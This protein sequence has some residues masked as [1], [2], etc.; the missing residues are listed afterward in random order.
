MLRLMDRLSALVNQLVGGFAN[1]GAGPLLPHNP[2]KLSIPLAPAN[3]SMSLSAQA[4][5]SQMTLQS[6]VDE[7]QQVQPLH[8]TVNAT[9]LAAPAAYPITQSPTSQSLI[10]PTASGC[11]VKILHNTRDQFPSSPSLAGPQPISFFEGAQNFQMRDVINVFNEVGAQQNTL[12]IQRGR[13]SALLKHPNMSGTRVEY[14]PNSRKPDVDKLCELELNSTILVLCIHGPAGIGKSTLAGHLS[15]EFR[16]AGRLAASIF[17]GA[18][19]TESSDPETIIKMIAHEIGCIHP[20]AIPKILEAMDQCH[21]TSLEIHLQKFVLEP[22][23]SL[24]HPQPLIV[25]MD[26]MDEWRDHPRFIKALAFLNSD[27]SVVKFILTDRLN[28]CASRLPGV[29]E[30]SI[31]TYALG[32]ISKEV[33]KAYFEKYL[34]TVPWVDGRKAS[35]PDVEKLTELSGGLPVWASTVIALLLH[36]FSET[37]P[38]ETLAEIVGSHRQVGGTDGLAQ[39]YRQALAHLFPSSDAQRHFRRYLGVTIVILEPLSLSDFSTLAGIPS[40][41][42]IHIQFALSSLQIKSPS[43]GSEKMIHP[44]TTLFHLSFLEY[45]QATTTETSFAISAFDSHSVLG[46]A[47]LKQLASL[48]ASSR[49]HGLPLRAIQRYAVK[50]WPYHVSKGTPRLKDQWARTEH[51]SMLEKVTAD[52]QQ[53]WVAM[54]LE[55]LIPGV[56][57]SR[58]RKEGSMTSILSELVDCLDER[59]GDQ[60]VFQVALLEVAV[61]I[62]G[63]DADIWADLGSW[64]YNRAKTVGSLQMYD[65]AVEAFRHA[66]RLQ[67]NRSRAGFLVRLASALCSCYNKTGNIDFLHEAISNHREALGLRPAPHPDRS[68]SLNRLANALG[69]LYTYNGDIKPLTEAISLLR[70]ALTLC[71]GPHP[72]RPLSLNNLATSLGTL[73]EY[74]GDMDASQE[75][76]S[77]YR[78]ALSLC[79]AH[80]PLRFTSL[81]NLA[82]S[83]NILFD[84]TKDIGTLNESISLHHEALALCP[85]PHPDRVM[86]LNN[87]ALSLSALSECNGDIDAL[88]GAISLYREALPLCSASHPHRSVLFG[89]LAGRLHSLFQHNKDIGTLNECIS[90]NREALA[91]CPSSQPDR[92]IWLDGLAIALRSN[93]EC[94]GD[95]EALNEAISLYHEALALCPSPNP[96][97]PQSLDGLAHA[98]LFQF[99]LN[100]AMENLDEAISLRRELL[101]LRSPGHR[102]RKDNVERLVKLLEKRRE[103]TGDEQDGDEIEAL[104]AELAA[105]E[106]KAGSEPEK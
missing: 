45:V 91:L 36:P 94:N 38:H 7:R 73:F 98:L 25:I 30:V 88:H 40:H 19:R 62:D 5:T 68:E 35:P 12:E 15:D 66:L 2:S 103:A 9:Y 11:E 97:R 8:P 3:S 44:A 104:K 81:N 93:Y 60:W 72:D 1:T 6:S 23:R 20:R 77:L 29:D 47:C 55:N 75:A 99:E 54:F 57:E 58:I 53:R 51:C 102:L 14:L 63:G 28:P 21:G 106:T 56:D 26:A 46:I 32:P 83:L 31:Y 16:S 37:P 43:P 24:S 76:I 4:S 84:H 71:P 82:S 96:R 100:G 70:E 61:R 105:V 42:I 67:Q 17:L 85:E 74:Y 50:Y 49:N 33:I 95:I 10:H 78:E 101:C 18:I 59:D 48:P 90:L 92:A 41:L 27:S 69:D 13:L 39:L 87:L 64:Y 65:E 79:P 80:H 22:L 34:E 86:S 89:N 52:T